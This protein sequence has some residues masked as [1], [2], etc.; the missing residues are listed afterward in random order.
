MSNHDT[1]AVLS[2]AH[3]Q[4]HTPDT[5]EGDGFEVD[6]GPVGRKTCL[7]TEDS[8]ALANDAY[9]RSD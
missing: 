3:R 7:R 6:I 1:G 2:H 4:R 8:K 9:Y 5:D